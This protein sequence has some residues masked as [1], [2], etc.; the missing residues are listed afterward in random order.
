MQIVKTWDAAPLTGERPYEQRLLNPGDLAA[1]CP[2]AYSHF[3]ESLAARRKY[4]ESHIDRISLAASLRRS[5][6]RRG[7]PPSVFES[8]ERIKNDD[9]FLII[10]GQQPGLLGGP[11]FTYYKI[12]HAIALAKRLTR[13]RKE[14]FIPALWDASEDHDFPEIA[15]VYW[16]SKEREIASYTWPGA[17]NNR[18]P[19]FRIPIADCPVE[20]LLKQIQETT[21]PTEF[22][23]SVFDQIRDCV[24]GAETYPDFFD[25]LLW[26]VFPNDGLIIIRPEEAW[27]REHSRPLLEREIQEPL[28]SAEGVER[29]GALLQAQGLPPQIH[30]RADRTSFFLMEKEERIPVYVE[31]EGFIIGEN[32]RSTS[33]DLLRRLANAPEDFSSSAILRPVVQDALL[34]TAAAVLGPSEIAYHFL[35]N[36][37]YEA[38]AVPRPGLIPRFGFTLAE[39]R[40]MKWMERYG[41]QPVDWKEHPAALVKRITRNDSAAAWEMERRSAETAMANLFDRWKQQAQAHDPTLINPLSKNFERM[42]SEL[43]Q[44]EALLTRRIGEKNGQI[45]KHIESLKN[46]LYPQ[47]TLQERR[48]TIF[49][50]LCKYGMELLENFQSIGDAAA[51]GAHEIVRIP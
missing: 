33:A 9:C 16:L 28:R 20:E 40:E 23:K 14:T 39:E 41:L 29:I 47:G 25:R 43:K 4:A 51:D 5:H 24:R 36:D 11:L 12:L 13:E 19:Y 50:Y 10:T 22:Q 32:R 17:A 30:K 6:E 26:M 3:D 37:T 46:S 31:K 1:I 44:T 18:R 7:A 8:I 27:M 48:Y 38:H 45:L 34:P 42:L 35:L 21:H 49:S 15:S 2:P